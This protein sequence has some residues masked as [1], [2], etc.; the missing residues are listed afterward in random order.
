L[1]GV[2]GEG[3]RVASAVAAVGRQ[4]VQRPQRVQRGGAQQHGNQQK[5]AQQQ[6]AKREFREHRGLKKA[7]LT[8][9]MAKQ[10]RSLFDWHEFCLRHGLFR[11][12]SFHY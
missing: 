11:L 3:Q 2:F 5:D 12:R 1:L 4:A 10:P 6:L 7:M 8:N 9:H